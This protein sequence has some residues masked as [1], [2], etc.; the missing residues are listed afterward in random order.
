M[1]APGEVP[2]PEA[3]EPAAEAAS[4]N[5]QT[6]LTPEQ[7]RQLISTWAYHR[8]EQRGFSGGSPEQ[9]WLEAEAAL[10][11]GTVSSGGRYGRNHG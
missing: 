3:A 2:G 10:D 5:A 8:A 9:D 4:G 1:Q 7:R 11:A 6:P